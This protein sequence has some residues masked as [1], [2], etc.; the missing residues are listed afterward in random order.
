M[1]IFIQNSN[2]EIYAIGNNS[3][4]MLGVDDA[5]NAPIETLTKLHL[6]VVDGLEIDIMSTGQFTNHSFVAL[7][8]N[9]NKQI[10]YSFGLNEYAQQ[11]HQFPD[12]YYTPTRISLN[13]LFNNTQIT[14]I[15]TGNKHSLF[16]SAVGRVYSCGLNDKGQCG[17][18]VEDKDYSKVAELQ[19]VPFLYEITRICCG[20]NHNLCIDKNEALWCFG[21]NNDGQLGLG[22][23]Y[24]DKEHVNTAKINPYFKGDTSERKIAFIDCGDNH[25]LCINIKGMAFMFG[26]NTYGQCAQENQSSVNIPFCIQ[27]IE[28]YADIVFESGSGGSEH[29]VLL[30]IKPINA[31]YGFGKN[32][33]HQTGNIQNEGIQYKPFLITK[34][35]IGLD[36]NI[37]NIVSV[38]CDYD[39][40][41]VVCET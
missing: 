35:D 12:E 37:T 13:G 29:T 11:G 16:L 31:L 14:Q 22:N 2:N 3:H 32:Q 36:P 19:M 25:S 26:D 23:E 41:I 6:N 15:S 10:F 40:T 34:E 7:K 1:N 39:T 17:T 30:S 21:S 38:L 24:K 27:S 4:G 9:E 18:E 20:A 5:F 8:D 28:G 33:Y